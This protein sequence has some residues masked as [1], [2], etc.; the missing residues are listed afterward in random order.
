MTHIEFDTLKIGDALKHNFSDEIVIV[1]DIIKT[2]DSNGNT[3]FDKPFEIITDDLKYKNDYIISNDI[4]TNVL[5]NWTIVNDTHVLE[6]YKEELNHVELCKC[7]GICEDECGPLNEEGLCEFCEK[8][9]K[10]YSSNI[11]LKKS[12]TIFLN[13]ISTVYKNYDYIDITEWSNRD[14]YDIHISIDNKDTHI[15]Y[16]FEIFE[17]MLNGITALGEKLIK[18]N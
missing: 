13:D 3:I 2:V 17:A 4:L 5:E 8:A 10:L 18:Y 7:C 11:S 15:S 6:T 12:I 1:K 14:G 9:K 16:P